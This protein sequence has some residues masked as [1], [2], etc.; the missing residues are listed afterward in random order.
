MSTLNTT[1]RL[2]KDLA[3]LEAELNARKEADR[4]ER[5]NA[6]RASCED[7]EAEH[8]VVDPVTGEVDTRHVTS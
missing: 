5:E 8:A 1:K 6:E 4:V 7:E 2:M 3:A